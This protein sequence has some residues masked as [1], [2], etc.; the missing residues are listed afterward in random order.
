MNGNERVLSLAGP[1]T[2]VTY[3]RLRTQLDAH[4]DAGGG[5]VDWSA[6]GAV[7]SSALSLLLH[8][9]RRHAALEHRALPRALDAL[10]ALYGVGDLVGG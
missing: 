8:A 3:T 4:L 7:D 5:V 2:F 9:R 10:A 6:V 1:A